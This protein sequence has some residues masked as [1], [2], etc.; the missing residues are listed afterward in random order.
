MPELIAW[1]QHFGQ[2]IFNTGKELLVIVCIIIGFQLIIIRRLPANLKKISLGF[3]Y[4]LLGLALFSEGLDMALLPLG[5]IMASQLTSANFLQISANKSIHW[6]QYYW[7]YAFAASFG[8]A[9]TLA[10]P[11]LLAV[12]Q[13]AEQI[14]GGAIRAWRLRIAVA[15]G[16]A[17]GIALGTLR[18][19][20][21]IELY[22][23]L[24]V[25]YIFVLIQTLLAPKIIIGIAYDAAGGVNTSTVTVPLITALGLGL[26]STIP[27]RNPLLEGFGLI[28][29]ASLFPIIAVLG[30]AQ[31]AL[32]QNKNSFTHKP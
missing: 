14:S 17:L 25:G 10:E 26:A 29:F 1:L 18:I 5:K 21:G 8:F 2:S 30:Y 24:I 20:M 23:Y 11:S 16:V 7:V 28:A 15:V 12:A 31:I 22:Y 27:E 6:Q 4:V 3:I 19:V 13:K 32:W 9:T